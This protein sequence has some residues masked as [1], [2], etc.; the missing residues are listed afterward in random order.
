[1]KF[2]KRYKVA[3]AT[4]I[5]ILIITNPSVKDFKDYVGTNSYTGLKES[6]LQ[7]LSF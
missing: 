4:I 3:L 6:Q 5:I 2:N 7:K 1:M